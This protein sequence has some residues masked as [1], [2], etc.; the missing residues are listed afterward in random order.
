[1]V[2]KIIN[3]LPC[4]TVSDVHSFLGSCGA[5][6]IFIEKFTEVACPLV[7]LTHKNASFMWKE[8][9]QSA[10][11]TLKSKV[12]TAPALV[13]LDYPCGRLIVVT[14]DSSNI[15]VGW[16]VYQLDTT[17][18]RRPSRYGS[19]AWDEF[20]A[21]Y[22]CGMLNNPDIQP[23]N[24]M[25]CWITAILLFSFELVHVPGKDHAEPDGL[26]RR[27]SAEGDLEEKDD[28]WIDEDLGLGVWVNKWMGLGGEECQ[29]RLISNMKSLL[30]TTSTFSLTFLNFSLTSF[31][32]DI[33]M[34]KNLPLYFDFLSTTKMLTGLE[35][36]ELKTF[37]KQAMCFFVKDGKLWRRNDS[38]I[39]QLVILDLKKHLSLIS[40]AHHQVGHKQA[41]STHKHLMDCFLWPGLDCNIAW[42]VKTCHECQ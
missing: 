30:T 37:I 1:Q 15:T 36:K 6:R 17:R 11:G 42:F 23:N 27:R 16:I 31:N 35:E 33:N 12:M 39:H 9:Q 10:M 25:N 18:R 4:Q 3:W 29:R 7:S 32:Q 14:V 22:I 34:D 8:V 26:S 38:G 40:Q 19:I 41:F 13:P 2:S 28:E 24:A 21:K 20:D 5:V